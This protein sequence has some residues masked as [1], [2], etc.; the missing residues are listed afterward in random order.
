MQAY[1]AGECEEIELEVRDEKCPDEVFGRLWI[2]PHAVSWYSETTGK[3]AWRSWESL[4]R[5]E[6]PRSVES[7][8]TP[9]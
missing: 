4:A 2:S 9:G 5:G 3:Y 1:G 8:E 7:A 6:T